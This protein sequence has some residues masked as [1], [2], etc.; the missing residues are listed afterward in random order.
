[1]SGKG[2]VLITGAGGLTG[3]RLVTRL[4]E[5]GYA[6]VLLRHGKGKSDSDD[7]YFWY[8]PEKH[9]DPGALN[10]VSHIIHL[11]GTG[12]ADKRWSRERKSEII[13]SRVDSARLL[14]EKVQEEGIKLKCYISASATG[15]YKNSLMPLPATENETPSND[16]LGQTCRLWEESADLFGDSGI[17]TIKVRTGIVLA[18]DGG[19]MGKIMPFA[20]VGLFTW[21]GSG[22]QYFPWIHIDDLCSIY[23]KAIDD[24][25]MNGPY[26]AVAPQN[27]ALS[28][29]MRTFAQIKGKPAIVAG[30]PSF[31]V[32]IL[33][34]EMAVMLL[35]GRSIS[36]SAIES[37]GF[38]FRYRT[39][40]EALAQIV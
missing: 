25:S 19:F 40:E 11:A 23:L 15:I 22:S 14:F 16:F 18:P 12:I 33:M 35:E 28:T 3:R 29:F 4:K 2:K 5:A 21:F 10:G 38:V 20:K 27:I 39:A 32:K 34:G 24:E 30:I 17:R 31:L 9:I 8:P 36:S 7:S 1:M 37:A 6:V 26:N 13:S